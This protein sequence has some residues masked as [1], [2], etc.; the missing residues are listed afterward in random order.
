MQHEA[1]TLLGTRSGRTKATSLWGTALHGRTALSGRPSVLSDACDSEWGLLRCAESWPESG[2]RRRVFIVGTPRHR[3]RRQGGTEYHLLRLAQKPFVMTLVNNN[4]MRSVS[5]KRASTGGGRCSRSRSLLSHADCSDRSVARRQLDA[6]R[7][8]RSRLEEWAGPEG[9]FRESASASASASVFI[10]H[11]KSWGHTQTANGKPASERTNMIA[12]PAPH[13]TAC[14]PLWVP[15]ALIGRPHGDAAA[16]RITQFS[17]LPRLSVASFIT[18][19]CRLSSLHGRPL[20]AHIEL[21]QQH[22]AG[23]LS[24]GPSRR[25]RP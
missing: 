13:L 12:I 23:R 11:H 18:S 25:A 4:L 9:T 21:I 15:S 22:Q 3:W 20:A 1:R 17:P 7:R 2:L 16:V 8:Q 19:P 24:A 6:R 5:G 14:S 10:N